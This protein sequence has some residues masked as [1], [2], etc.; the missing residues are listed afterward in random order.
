[1]LEPGVGFRLEVVEAG[2]KGMGEIWGHQAEDVQ[3]A[4]A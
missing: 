1:M 3:N 4:T 2:G